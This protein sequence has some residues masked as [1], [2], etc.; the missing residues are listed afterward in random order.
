M[1]D[2]ARGLF[3]G[4]GNLYVNKTDVTFGFTSYTESCV[5]DFK[6]II[7]KISGINS[8]NSPFFTSAWHI[9]W[10]GRQQVKKILDILYFNSTRHLERKFQLY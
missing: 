1:V 5:K 9:N 4:D 6:S 7:T 10:R 3:D 8:N 2:F